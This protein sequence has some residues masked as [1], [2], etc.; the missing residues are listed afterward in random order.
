LINELDVGRKQITQR[1]ID[2]DARWN[3][4][5][6]LERTVLDSQQRMQK[7]DSQLNENAESLGKLRSKIDGYADQAVIAR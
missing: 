4:F 5:S 7:I 2:L 1:I 6:R 3:D